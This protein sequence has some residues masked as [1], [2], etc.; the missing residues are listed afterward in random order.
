M[1]TTINIR[2]FEF[3]VAIAVKAVCGIIEVIN[4][5]SVIFLRGQ[6]RDWFVNIVVN[7]LR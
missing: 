3:A 6:G 7:Q 4:F 5:L 2:R 1:T